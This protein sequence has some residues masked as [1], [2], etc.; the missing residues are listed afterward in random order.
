MNATAQPAP[1]VEDSPAEIMNI[2]VTA[3]AAPAL[4]PKKMESLPTSLLKMVSVF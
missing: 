1:N 3:E 2:R 4:H